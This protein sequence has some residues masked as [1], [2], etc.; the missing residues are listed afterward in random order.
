MKNDKVVGK[1][2]LIVIVMTVI[3]GVGLLFLYKGDD[4]TISN[5]LKNSHIDNH[6][7]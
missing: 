5:D 2:I 1:F 6:F 7:I 4:K 3:N